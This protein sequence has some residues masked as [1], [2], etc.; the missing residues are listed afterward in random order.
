MTENVLPTDDE[1]HDPKQAL[2]AQRAAQ[3]AQANASLR[4][5]GMAVSV[6]DM[7]LQA[8]VAAGDMTADEAVAHYVRQAAGGK[9]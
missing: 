3:F 2:A 7:E 4:L 1:G 9:K 8:L 5:E 6:D